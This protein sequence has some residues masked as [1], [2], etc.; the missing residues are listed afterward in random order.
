VIQIG[1]NPTT[2]ALR[3][4]AM[5]CPI[6]FGLIGWMASRF[7][8]AGWWPWIGI[9]VGLVLMLAGLWRPMSLRPVYVA[10]MT[11]SAP[12][13]WI[14]SNVFAAVFFFLILTPLGLFFRVIRRD[15]LCL[16]ERGLSTYWREHRRIDDP[17]G[18]YRQG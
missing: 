10:I 6:G 11:L 16:R 12:I 13:G 8:A 9:G 1:W 15:P 18:Y 5:A 7:G 3:Q 2:R 4:F 14:V 17:G